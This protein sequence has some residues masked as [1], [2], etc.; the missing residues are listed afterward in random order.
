MRSELPRREVVGTWAL[1]VGNVIGGLGLVWD[2]QWHGD[3]GPDTFF[4]AP[5][6]LMYLGMATNGLASLAVV[7][8][9]TWAARQETAAGAGMPAVT[10]LGT[11]Q[12][13]LPFL[14]CGT[15]GA[16]GLVYGL[17]DLWWHEV[18]GF[19]VTPTSPPHVGMSL[20]SIFDVT[21]ML[22]AFVALRSQR[23]GRIG[24]AAAAVVGLP[25]LVFL[26]YS[27]PP[28]PG[29]V[30]TIVAIAATV[31]LIVSVVAGALRDAGV[32]ALSALM[33]V[34]MLSVNWFFA[35]AAT[36]A[37]A[38]ALGLQIRD[39]AIGV[40]LIPITLPFGYPVA[41][42]VV[43]G[44]MALARRRGISPR[45]AMPVLGGLAGGVIALG[46][47]AVPSI[48]FTSATALVA[49]PVGALCAWLGWQL[50]S[51]ARRATRRVVDV[52]ASARLT[53]VEA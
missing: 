39:Y 13:P 10:V 36:S 6:L 11:F 41:A 3:V 26:T 18:Y 48:G 8:R 17:G 33:F 42:L 5:H 38:D 30:T 52:A 32:I 21:G 47:L 49:L 31:V 34:A 7:L 45:G 12:A 9:S 28:V 35:P 2:I 51:A 19:D 40:P 20:M 27:T 46:Y 53:T 29:L 24:I 25:G 4:T 15:A 22:L 43:A 16:V 14:I 50:G 23:A 44:G 37:Y 1:L